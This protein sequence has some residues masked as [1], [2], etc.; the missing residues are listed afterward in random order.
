MGFR[1]LAGRI[2][3]VLT[4]AEFSGAEGS[5][6]PDGVIVAPSVAEALKSLGTRKDVADIF[7]IGGQRA[8]EEALAMEACQ[9]IYMTRVGKDVECDAFFPAF[10][11]TQYKVVHVSKTISHKELP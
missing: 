8:Y 6:Y 1:P 5:P 3:V 4:S 11:E 10:D 2:N 9:R 7:V